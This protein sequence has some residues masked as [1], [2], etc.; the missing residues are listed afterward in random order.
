MTKDQQKRAFYPDKTLAAL[1][2][3]LKDIKKIVKIGNIIIPI[4][5]IGNYVYNV[6]CSLNVLYLLILNCVM[7][8]LLIAGFV[9]DRIFER[10]KKNNKTPS[11]VWKKIFKWLK[12]IVRITTIAFNIF[13]LSTGNPSDLQIITMALTIG[14][15]AIQLVIEII[16]IVIAYYWELIKLAFEMDLEEF[17]NSGLVKTYNSLG[18]LPATALELLDKPLATIANKKNTSVEESSEEPQQEG[19]KQQKMKK[20]LVENATENNQKEAEKKQ[21]Q[22]QDKRKQKQER[23]QKAWDSVKTHLSEIFKKKKK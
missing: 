21:E 5:M 10:Q 6:F 22:K 18:N 3:P 16:A 19:K 11:K 20:W 4:I 15:I 7:V 2:K 13:A 14:V 12:Y 23:V 17:Q 9:A 1:G 8:A